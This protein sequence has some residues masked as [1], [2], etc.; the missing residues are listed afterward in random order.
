MIILTS[1]QIFD[2]QETVDEIVKSSNLPISLIFVG[3]G[4]GDFSSFR[5]IDAD[6]TPLWSTQQEKFSERDC[7][8]FI[9]F[10]DYRDS[11]GSLVREIMK[12][13]PVQMTNY[14]RNANIRPN[15][16]IELEK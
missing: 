10:N 3:I 15:P 12:Q 7:V 16:K 9:R 13:I 2:Y 4:D 6:I 1:G 8:Q 11:P 5:K 14:F